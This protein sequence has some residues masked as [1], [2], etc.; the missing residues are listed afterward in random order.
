VN[1]ARHGFHRLTQIDPGTYEFRRCYPGEVI[2]QEPFWN[3]LSRAGN[4]VVILDIPLT[5][6]SGKLNG[7]QMVEW[8]SHDAAYGFHT[9]PP[10]LKKDV[11]RRFGTHPAKKPCDSYGRSPQDFCNLR[12]LLIE[13]VKKKQ[14]LTLHYMNQGEWDFFAQVFTE[15]H[16][17]GHQCWHLHDPA[18]PNYDPNIVSVTGNPIREVYKAID[19]AIGRILAQVDDQTLVF[20]LATH[21]M[22]HNIGASF[23]LEDILERMNYLKRSPREVDSRPKKSLIR[24][25]SI[26]PKEEYKKLPAPIQNV[27]KPA[28]YPL[29]HLARHFPIGDDFYPSSLSSRMDLKHCKCFPHENGN[30]VSGIRINLLGREPSGLIK[31][32]EELEN[33]CRRIREDLLAITEKDSGRPM[34]NRVL[35]TSDFLEGEFINNLPDLLVEWSEDKLIGSKRLTGG[36]SYRL[37]LTSDKIGTIQG[38]YTY[39]RTGDHRPEGLL[40]VYGPGINPGDIGRTISIMDLAPTFL[41]LFGIKNLDMDGK[42]IREVVEATH[43]LA[44]E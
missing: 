34:V 20:L 40:I 12:D 14:E 17:A 37:Q 3:H 44:V 29:Y 22:A 7:I 18:H 24:R 41:N 13:G 42:P 11:V 23:L 36:P 16:C 39:C 9:W 35:K 10:A 31:P 27:L 38:E 32:G 8:G 1:P 30:L 25:M 21:R 15:G 19:R 5:A 4:K 28:L 2:K 6:T 33:L 26:L 43:R